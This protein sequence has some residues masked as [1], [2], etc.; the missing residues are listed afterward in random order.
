LLGSR[1]RSRMSSNGCI[2][3]QL[4]YIGETVLVFLPKT[5]HVMSVL[6]GVYYS[7]KRNRKHVIGACLREIIV[8]GLILFHP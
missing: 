3:V 8:M 5:N 2:N 7:H 6:H 1:S 4:L